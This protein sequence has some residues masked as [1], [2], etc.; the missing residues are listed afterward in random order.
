ML[1]KWL[2]R[3]YLEFDSLWHMIIVS[4]H[5]PHPFEWTT[6]G[7]KGTFH[8]P[9]K[10]ITFK[11]PS[12]SRFSCCFVGDGKYT[13][14]WKDQWVRENSLY[15]IFLHLYH[16]YSSK[17][18]TISDILVRFENLVSF[19]FVF[20]HNLINRETT[21]VTS[22]LSLLEGCPFRKGRRDVRVWDPNPSQGFSCKYMFSMLLDPLPL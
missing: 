21:E 3:F 4:K 7:V 20:R 9:G 22:F 2:W 10:D 16:L 17:N 18:C 19:A 8:N 15:L 6:L 14:F 1:A 13:Y 5:G 11:L 12:F